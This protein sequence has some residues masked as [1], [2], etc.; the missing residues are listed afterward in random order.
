MDK[1]IQ[2][3]RFAASTDI[4]AELV[5]AKLGEL[6][7]QITEYTKTY[8]QFKQQID[9]AVKLAEQQARDALAVKAAGNEKIPTGNPSLDELKSSLTVLTAINPE[10]KVAIESL[11]D[12]VEHKAGDTENEIVKARQSV[13]KWF[14][15]GMERVSG[16]Y[17]RE[18]QK[19][20]LIIGIVLALVFNMDSINLVT[21]LWQ[22]PAL[23]QALSEQAAVYVNEHTDGVT[24]FTPTSDDLKKFEAQFS[25]INVPMGWI[26]ADYPV[27]AWNQLVDANG[28]MVKTCTLNPIQPTDEYGIVAGGLCYPIINAPHF[29]DPVGIFLKIIG[30]VVSG[31]AAGQGAPFWFDV[32]RNLINFRPSG[33]SDKK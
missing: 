20:A 3:A 9:A 10:L 33:T 25:A 7:A 29:T 27:N 8:P 24:D 14:D 16:W 6:K 1:L 5:D 13:E 15:S 12:G 30:L 19:S 26:G 28:V 17:R 32:L 22:Q 18:T 4:G 23:R 2:L 31:M 21:Q 11:I